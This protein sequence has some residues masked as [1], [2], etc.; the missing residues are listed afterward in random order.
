MTQ[1]LVIAAPA[2]G[3]GK[4]TVATGLIG[5]AARAG[6]A[7]APH[8][9]G[10]DYIDPGYHALATGRAGRNLD[11]CWS[12]RSGSRRCSGTGARRRRH[13]RRRGRD[14]A[15][16]RRRRVGRPGYGST[17]HVAAAART[18]RWCW[19]WTPRRSRAAAAL[20]HGFAPS[21]R[22]PGRRGDPQPGRQRPAR[23]VLRD[24]L[25]EV[26]V[27]VLGVLPRLA[28]LAVPSRHLGLVPAAEHGRRPRRRSTAMAEL[29]AAH[30]DLDAVLAPGPRSAP[31]PA[32]DASADSPMGVA[33]VSDRR[34]AR[35]AALRP[36]V[37]V[38]G[39]AAFTF[40][41]AE[42][43]SCSPPRGRGRG[44]RPAARRGAA[45]RHRRAGARA[46][47]SPRC[48]RG[49]GRE[50]PAAR[51]RRRA[52]AL[53]APGRT[54][55]AAGCSTWRELDGRADVRGSCRR[56]GDD[57]PAHPGLPGGGGARRLGAVRRRRAR[58]AGHEFHRSA[59]T[60]RAGAAP[61]WGWRGGEPEGFVTAGVHA[62]YLHTHP[63]GAPAAVRASP[64]PPH[65]RPR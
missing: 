21:T 4:T 60:P 16:R 22:R 33:P 20:V 1:A 53:G 24:A 55:S 32:W 39:G 15:V 13:R 40:S 28:E 64:A 58:V 62:S 14:G 50:R 42:T 47:A 59:V 57:R 17:A 35:P 43:P 5:R 56:G 6:A 26:G 51:R 45:R 19:W 3:S 12:A 52:R 54:P 34:V 44:L 46:A 41:Y 9:V 63:A 2:S 27:P 48:T 31:G 36:V 29:V 38:A 30:V 25:D 49:A 37:A 8:K 61:A 7:V 11:P 18:R 65:D 23:E 10:P